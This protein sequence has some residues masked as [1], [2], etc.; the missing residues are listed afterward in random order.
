MKKWKTALAGMAAGLPNGLFGAG[1]GMLLVPLLRR[2]GELD[3]QETFPTALAVMT[4]L[5]LVSLTIYL[6]R[7][8]L[9][10][11]VALPYLISGLVGGLVGGLVFHKVSPQLLHR[12]FGALIL[13]AGVRM[14]L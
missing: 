14:L 6:L 1:G 5:C 9:D 2:W 12:L 4:P 7:G 3:E 11:P 8:A 13:Y 10:L